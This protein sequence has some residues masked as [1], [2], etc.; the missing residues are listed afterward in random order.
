[1][2]GDGS[3]FV[4]IYK[5]ATQT[6]F[7]VKLV[8]RVN[9]HSK[10]AELMKSLIYY[11]ECGNYYPASN[12]NSGEFIVTRLSDITE[13]IIPF[14]EKNQIKGEKSYDFQDFCKVAQLRKSEAH[15]T[16]E[17]LA[18]IRQIKGGM[19]RGRLN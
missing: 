8:F 17:G 18:K 5:D 1:V 9:Q 4:N 13:K 19:N 16:T 11:L 2:S 14:F 10:D 7:T 12:Q 15:L 3:F 6:G